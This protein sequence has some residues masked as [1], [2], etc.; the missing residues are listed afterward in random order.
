M[1]LHILS[2][3]EP[4][5]RLVCTAVSKRWR[6]IVE[7]GPSWQRTLDTIEDEEAL[8]DLESPVNNRYFYEI[9]YTSAMIYV[10]IYPL[11]NRRRRRKRRKERLE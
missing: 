11:E 9:R 8:C 4:H 6:E 2:F 3:L 7:A 5:E 10:S 1:A